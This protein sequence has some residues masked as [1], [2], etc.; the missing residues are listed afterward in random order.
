MDF[1]PKAHQKF[2]EAFYY[3]TFHLH[4]IDDTYQE[5]RHLLP[6]YL[7]YQNTYY[8]FDIIRVVP[9][10][11]I[12]IKIAIAGDGSANFESTHVWFF[13]WWRLNDKLT[14]LS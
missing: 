1:S 14:G 2:E 12:V 13:R 7:S 10:F 4:F 6:E 9:L 3:K 5:G 8:D 11:A